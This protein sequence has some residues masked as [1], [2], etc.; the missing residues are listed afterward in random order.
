MGVGRFER[1]FNS[2]CAVVVV[3]MVVIVGELAIF[4]EK[5]FIFIREVVIL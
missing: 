3:V 5:M 4:N 2:K 1:L